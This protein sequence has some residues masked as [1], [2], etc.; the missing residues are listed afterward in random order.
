M[1]I[2][3]RGATTTVAVDGR[4]FKITYSQRY[5]RLQVRENRRLLTEAQT[6]QDALNSVDRLVKPLYN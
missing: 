2:T 5:R 4:T 1:Q 3:S 6:F